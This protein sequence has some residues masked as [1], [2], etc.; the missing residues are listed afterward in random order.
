M[1]S[2]K[3]T[4]LRHPVAPFK[5]PH[6]PPNRP[7]APTRRPLTLPNFVSKKEIGLGD[8]IRRA[9]SAMGIK[10]CPACEKRARYLNERV[11]FGRGK[12]G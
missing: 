1:K 12:D 9:T 3:A 4:P 10:P 5:H 8:V 6:A 7:I 11:V 2:N